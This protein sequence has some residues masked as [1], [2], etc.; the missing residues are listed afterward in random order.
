MYLT[1][2]LAERGIGSNRGLQRI[3]SKVDDQNE[4]SAEVSGRVSNLGPIAAKL[5]AK[6]GTRTQNKAK[7]TNKIDFV[8]ALC[9][10]GSP[11]RSR[12]ANSTIC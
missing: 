12:P 7:R 9:K 3:Q 6:A 8:V 5:G 11:V 1:F 10:Q 4:P 2:M